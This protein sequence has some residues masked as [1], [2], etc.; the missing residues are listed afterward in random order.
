MKIRFFNTFE[1]VS[2]IY[3]DLLPYLV[4]NANVEIEAILSSAIYRSGR[5]GLDE[6]LSHSHIRLR[7][8]FSGNFRPK[9]KLFKF[10]IMLMYAGCASLVAIFGKPV[11]LNIF[12]SQPPLFALLG[13]LLKQLRR[14]P[15]YCL[16]MDLYPDVAIAAGVLRKEAWM[17][18]LLINLSRVLLMRADAVIVIGRCMAERVKARG[19]RPERI[20]M[21]TNWVDENVILPIFPTENTLRRTLNLNGKFVVLY[22]GNMGVS[23]YFDDL[24]A[25]ARRCYN[26]QDLCF[27]FIGDGI[28]RKEIEK[29][30]TLYHLT[31]IVLLPFQPYER[32]SESLSLGDVHFISL[33]N[34]FEGLVVPSKAYGALAVGRPILYQGHSEGEIARMVKE[35]CI[36]T[37]V[38]PDQPEMLEQAILQY[39]RH[40]ELARKQGAK[41]LALSR[42]AFSRHH[43][44]GAYRTLLCTRNDL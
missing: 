17:T 12:L 9:S 6:C 42:G 39:Y 29:A 7:R 1:P 14:Q 24:I 3:R 41:S 26:I 19:V 16:I 34:G 5:E 28:R 18:Q 31:N 33:R 23:H 11:D 22:S 36:G 35:A 30:I 2:I 15:Y 8:M 43:A 27:L 32:L 38:P 21:I 4:R 20:L 37:V 10:F 44:L 13:C 25:V 40:P